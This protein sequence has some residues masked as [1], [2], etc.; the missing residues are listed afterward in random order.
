MFQL[1]EIPQIFPIGKFVL[2]KNKIFFIFLFFNSAFYEDKNLKEILNKINLYN[3]NNTK[4][5]LKINLDVGFC[6]GDYGI[7]NKTKSPYFIYI[8][9]DSYFLTLDSSF[10]NDILMKIIIKSEMERKTFFKIKFE[11]FKN[12][13]RFEDYYKRV[14][15][16]VK[17]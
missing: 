2:F 8:K 5:K 17:K 6:F 4:E 12:S 7:I 13:Y 14:S 9:E 16:I 3:F 11:I 10:F 15:L 1:W